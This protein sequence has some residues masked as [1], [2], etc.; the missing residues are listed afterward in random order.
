MSFLN[1]VRPCTLS[2]GSSQP[3]TRPANR[4][5]GR[6]GSTRLPAHFG[7]QHGM[8]WVRMM[9]SGSPLRTN[10]VSFWKPGHFSACLWAQ[11]QTHAATATMTKTMSTRN[12]AGRSVA[13]HCLLQC[14]HSRRTRR[15]THRPEFET[16]AHMPDRAAGWDPSCFRPPTQ[17]K[18]DLNVHRSM[19]KNCKGHSYCYI[20]V[21][22]LVTIICIYHI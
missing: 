15:A 14:K 17:I 6:G 2:Q 9:R 3:W 8:Q 1:C 19:S 4:R 13:T 7:L 20:T 21:L 16:C 10:I 5:T 11:A 18:L 22:C 12:L